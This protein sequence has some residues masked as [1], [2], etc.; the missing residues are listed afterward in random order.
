M[1]DTTDSVSLSYWLSRRT[2]CGFIHLSN[3]SVRIADIEEERGLIFTFASL[4]SFCHLGLFSPYA[5]MAKVWHS[6]TG[7]R[8]QQVRSSLDVHTHGHVLSRHTHSVFTAP[9]GAILSTT[10]VGIGVDSYHTQKGKTIVHRSSISRK[11]VFKTLLKCF[12]LF[13]RL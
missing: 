2:Y 9:P 13:V 6:P 10:Q 11:R 1:T 8:T 12:P 4:L 7:S 3:C 5:I